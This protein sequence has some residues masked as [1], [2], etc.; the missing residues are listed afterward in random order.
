MPAEKTD[1]GG[2]WQAKTRYSTGPYVGFQAA[3]E[4]FNRSWKRRQPRARVGR[5][6]R[7]QLSSNILPGSG[8]PS[9]SVTPPEQLAVWTIGPTRV[10][11]RAGSPAPELAA[12]RFGP[13]GV[14]EA[15]W[16]TGI[17]E[18]RGSR[19]ALRGWM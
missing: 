7:T 17:V 1:A 13:A 16:K 14:F 18:V 19:R 6:C 2:P 11:I 15:V 8:E 12:V 5:V 9:G 3:G 10:K 4:D